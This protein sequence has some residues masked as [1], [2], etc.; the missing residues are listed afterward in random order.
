MVSRARECLQHTVF[1]MCWAISYNP[2]QLIV[3]S[4]WPDRRTFSMLNF[5]MA[6]LAA[7]R[8]VKRQSCARMARRQH[9]NIDGFLLHVLALR[10]TVNKSPEPE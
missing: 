1:L 8:S 2:S 4:E 5:S 10:I 9:T 3:S 6:S 7:G